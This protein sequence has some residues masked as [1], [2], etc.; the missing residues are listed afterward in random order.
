[1]LETCNQNQLLYKYILTDIWYVSTK[2]MQ[3]VKLTFNKDFIMGMK[4]N[5]LAVL[6][7][8]DKHQGRFVRIDSLTLEP[9]TTTGLFKRN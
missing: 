6:S 7:L 3:A 5:R 1:M 2:N 9:N 8:D 4:C